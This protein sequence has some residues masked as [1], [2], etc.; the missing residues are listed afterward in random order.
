M[1][2][3]DDMET[4]GYAADPMATVGA[5]MP[6]N[7]SAIMRRQPGPMPSGGRMMPGN[8]AQRALMQ[9]GA[10]FGGGMNE[11]RVRQLID[12][13]L[14]ATVPNWFSS[15]QQVPGSPSEG[16]LM[17]PLGMGTGVLTAAAPTLV[18][19]A[20]PQRPFQGER[21]VVNLAKTAGALTTP[22]NIS[23]FKI[24]E[25]SQL[26]SGANVLPAETFAPDAF[27]IRLKMTPATVGTIMSISFAATV[28]GG[29]SITVVAA[30]IGRAAWGPRG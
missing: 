23:D 17:S 20:Q 25:N 22:V 7:P 6:Y 14:R 24:G 12:E 9:R 2:D 18:L 15:Q 27:G 28:P 4:M 8:A 10:Q 26:V 3:D 29:E 11:A 21:L 30:I 19:T 13:H 1:Y 16:E 5:S